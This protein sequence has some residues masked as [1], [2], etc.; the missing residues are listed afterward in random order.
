[1]WVLFVAVA[2]ARDCSKT[3]EW[4]FSVYLAPKVAMVRKRGWCLDYCEKHTNTCACW[5]SRKEYATP[6][7]WGSG[8]YEPVFKLLVAGG[9]WSRGLTPSFD[10]IIDASIPTCVKRASASIRT[11]VSPGM[12]QLQ[13]TTTRGPINGWSSAIPNSWMMLLARAVSGQAAISAKAHM[14]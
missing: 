9:R 1:M 5:G 14:T 7:G 2:I 12:N 11:E 3:V 10:T 6:M 4:H 13:T 8:R